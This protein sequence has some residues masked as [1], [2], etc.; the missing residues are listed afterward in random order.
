MYQKLLSL[1]VSEDEIEHMKNNSQNNQTNQNGKRM[2]GFK[3]GM[4]QQTGDDN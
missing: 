1:G 4:K 2:I 3:I